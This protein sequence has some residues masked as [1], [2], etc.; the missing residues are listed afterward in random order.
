M[1]VLSRRSG[2]SLLIGDDVVIEVLDISGTQVKL[3]IRAPR[4]IPVLR[5]ELMATIRQ[6]EIA[7]QAI[8]SQVITRV[9]EVLK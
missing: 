3:G 7:A 2:E 6:N 4:K 5:G 1:L 8:P 9:L